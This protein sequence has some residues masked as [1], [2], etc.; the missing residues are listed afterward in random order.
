[1][2]TETLRQ[3]ITDKA[4]NENKIFLLDTQKSIVERLGSRLNGPYAP[5]HNPT[6]EEARQA[7]NTL[8]SLGDLEQD[9][10]IESEIRALSII[11][12]WAN[13]KIAA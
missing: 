2:D 3:I 7:L 13:A 1:M 8:D 9:E 5:T 10:P 12:K 11:F 4:T 6:D